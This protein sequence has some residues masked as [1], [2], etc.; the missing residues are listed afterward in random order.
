MT[1]HEIDNMFGVGANDAITASSAPTTPII[2]KQTASN[3]APTEKFTPVDDG[4]F[5]P[6]AHKK[7]I[8]TETKATMPIASEVKPAKTVAISNKTITEQVAIPPH[9]ALQNKWQPVD[10]S[11]PAIQKTNITATHSPPAFIVNDDGSST[12]IVNVDGSYEA[13]SD[14]IESFGGGGN[15]TTLVSPEE[16]NATSDQAFLPESRYAK[17][18]RNI[19]RRRLLS[20]SR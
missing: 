18:N 3:I 6:V 17:R 1:S 8:A 7:P 2:S 16:Y 9:P 14:A 11:V 12:Q 5:T 13:V 4:K 15:R 20:R 19:K 10:T